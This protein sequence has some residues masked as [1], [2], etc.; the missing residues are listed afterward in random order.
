M[1]NRWLRGYFLGQPAKAPTL[2][3]GIAVAKIKITYDRASY[4][5][6]ALLLATRG[7]QVVSAALATPVKT[8]TPHIISPTPMQRRFLPRKLKPRPHGPW[9]S[10]GYVRCDLI[11]KNSRSRESNGDKVII[12]RILTEFGKLGYRYVDVGTS[13]SHRLRSS[14]MTQQYLVVHRKAGTHHVPFLPSE[15]LSTQRKAELPSNKIFEE[16]LGQRYR[17]MRNGRTAIF[18]ALKLL[19]LRRRDQVFVTTSFETPYVSRCVTNTIA[20]ICT[21]TRKLTRRTKVIFVIHEFGVPHPRVFDLRTLAD[22]RGMV[23]IED[24]AHSIDSRFRNRRVGSIGDMAIYSFPKLLATSGGGALVL[25]NGNFNLETELYD[26]SRM[27]GIAREFEKIETYSKRRR[28]N[29]EHAAGL[30]R[31]VGLESLFKPS[32]NVTPYVFPLVIQD[33]YKSAA[34]CSKLGIESAVWHGNNL[35]ALPIHQFVS[36]TDIEVVFG[37][38]KSAL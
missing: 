28:R 33:P 26:V 31:L 6:Y 18:R 20:K 8:A 29:F 7:K 23:L 17:F 25:R 1:H 27:R 4:G 30:F 5:S 36:Q 34:E 14:F 10:V 19:A 12:S 21:P 11:P 2:P 37:A 15:H 3:H 22:E 38:V 9:A 13:S 32:E 16:Y 24:C 35:L